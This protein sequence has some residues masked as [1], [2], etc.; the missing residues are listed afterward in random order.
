M[1][2][3]VSRRALLSSTI[4]II[5]AAGLLAGMLMFATP[6]LVSRLPGISD[7]RD[8][9]S[10]TL[11]Q[12]LNLP[13]HIDSISV[14]AFG[15][16][17]LHGISVEANSDS[18]SLQ[19]EVKQLTVNLSLWQLLCKRD[20][21]AS[22]KR[23]IINDLVVST[24][25]ELEQVLQL[26]KVQGESEAKSL[27]FPVVIRK[28]TLS[29]DNW[30][31]YEKQITL[32]STNADLIRI[33]LS[34]STITLN[35][36]DLLTVAGVGVL[37]GSQLQQILLRVDTPYGNARIDGKVSWD[38]HGFW[39]THI[40]VAQLRLPF[41]FG[42][43]KT[44]PLIAVANITGPF[45]TPGADIRLN[46]GKAI[47]SGQL[48]WQAPRLVLKDGH[49]TL[50]Q[51]AYHVSGWFDTHKRNLSMDVVGNQV[52]AHE[53]LS[54]PGM[55]WPITGFVDGQVG[56]SG[57]FNDLVYQIN[58]QAVNGTAWKQAFSNLQARLQYHGVTTTLDN[59]TLM[60][61]GG[62]ID[63][64]GQIS[65]NQMQLKFIGES[66]PA[67]T[68]L[69]GARR[70]FNDP[71]LAGTFTKIGQLDIQGFLQGEVQINGTVQMPKITANL[72][73]P[74][75]QIAGVPAGN[76]SARVNNMPG[77]GNALLNWEF[78][79]FKAVIGAGSLKAQGILEFGPT[80]PSHLL[81]GTLE[82][83]S[84]EW[85]AQLGEALLNRF[86]ESAVA[87]GVTQIP[88][89][90]RK[91]MLGG[92]WQLIYGSGLGRQKNLSANLNI[93]AVVGALPVNIN[94]QGEGWMERWQLTK[95]VLSAANGTAKF[96]GGYNGGKLQVNGDCRNLP[97]VLVGEL[98]NLPQSLSGKL[99]GELH[100]SFDANGLTGQLFWEAANLGIDSSQLTQ[101]SG[102][103]LAANGRLHLQDWQ[104]NAAGR[105]ARL[106]GWLP[107]PTSLRGVHRASA[108]DLTLDIPLGPVGPLAAWLG[109]APSLSKW[110]SYLQS[111]DGTGCAQL[112][113]MGPL[114]AL[115]FN[116]EASLAGGK[117]A[118]PA[119]WGRVDQLEMA[120]QFNG[121]NIQL[122]KAS[123]QALGGRWSATGSVGIQPNNEVML[124]AQL[125]GSGLKPS[126]PG[127]SGQG[128]V[129]LRLNGPLNELQVSGTA[130][131]QQGEID[132]L[133]LHLPG[134]G[135]I[136]K[137]PINPYLDININAQRLRVKA[138]SLLDAFIG[139]S[140]RLN[141]TWH[142]PTLK[143]QLIADRG[144]LNYLGTNFVIDEAQIDFAPFRGVMPSLSLAA[145]AWSGQHVI[146]LRMNGEYPSLQAQLR[147]D[148]PLPQQ[149]ILALLS[150]PGQMSQINTSGINVWGQGLIE[151]LQG[152]IQSSLVDG[153]ESTLRYS[154]GLDHLQLQPNFS[155]RNLRIS[156]GK[157]IAPRV[158]LS[159]ERTI[160]DQPRDELHL[161]YR[162]DNGWK[163][164]GGLDEEGGLSVGIELKTKF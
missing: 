162:M 57:P 82:H 122:T 100:A 140:L 84:G 121:D 161:E 36:E 138:N 25:G 141:G 87:N 118:L 66:L 72:Q 115:A 70:W 90:L 8:V 76:W 9:V 68:V 132:I 54:W 120:L 34:K 64:S 89:Q 53:A 43:L 37:A 131:L 35:G 103:L 137:S 51:G 102:A 147:S 2:L 117:I 11:G 114:N 24:T 58:L 77:V 32:S 123:G 94:L 45:A 41:G 10:R 47:V 163:L 143:G 67:A 126:L 164:S 49:A 112:H 127:M 78:T 40:S 107:L 6:A 12:A 83:L 109:I 27:P 155:E 106:D 119:P 152:Q 18:A 48:L 104:G 75:A 15:N 31:V 21:E 69:A 56:I 14:V 139:G 80:S 98:A 86:G 59:L 20:I 7:V 5:A 160:F 88:K 134:T 133:S 46:Q 95:L 128:S 13:V 81:N 85:W 50:T 99:Q 125:T 111:I 38:A 4:I 22:I 146:T 148:P 74:R 154:L 73:M 23:V 142:E 97:A 129:N 17:R 79:D 110:G 30:Q 135:A 159:Y 3:W 52:P 63:G 16:M 91:G 145:T 153:V 93:D 96:T 44:T 150:W 26:I 29:G 1:S 124:Q 157:Y 136:G 156:A 101:A 113:V 28:V 71:G 144:Q 62:R 130:T 33:A 60:L 42:P 149:D 55:S 158:Y 65:G 105:K 151:V 19:A 39:D 61:A 92:R 116:G 108:V